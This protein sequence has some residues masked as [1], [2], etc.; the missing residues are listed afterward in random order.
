MRKL[1]AAY[2]KKHIVFMVFLCIMTVLYIV[3]MY[4][5]KPWYDELYTYYYFISRGPVYSAIHWPL[6]NNHVGFSILSSCLDWIKD[7]F[8]RLRAVS[9]MAAVANLILLY[10]FAGKFMDVFRAAGV[11]MLYAGAGL[12]YRLSFQGRGYTL[13]TTCFLVALIGICNICTKDKPGKRDHAMFIIGMIGGLYIVPT[14]LYWVVTTCL[15]G[16]FCLLYQKRYER[17]KAAI[18]DGLIAALVTFCLYS[19]LWLAVGANLLS[20][21]SD[22]AYYGLHQFKVLAKAPVRSFV[23]GMQYMLTSPAIQGMP[24]AECVKGMPLYLHTLFGTFYAGSGLIVFGICILAVVFCLIRL[25]GKKGSDHDAF[26]E[27]FLLT[28]IIVIPVMFLI[29]SVHPF[30]RVV[31]FLMIPIAFMSVFLLGFCKD[32]RLSYIT[33]AVSL[34]LAAW[35]LLLPANH[36]PVADRE[37]DIAEILEQIDVSGMNRIFYTDD[38]QKYVLKFYYDAAPAE[39][40]TILDADCV[41]VSREM[42]DPSFAALVWPLLYAYSGEMQEY[43]GA[44]FEKKAETEAY[45]FYTRK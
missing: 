38:Y 43:I 22:G 12:V 37:N 20:K 33:V 6:T 17:I 36:A 7:P 41:L 27:I 16:G 1:D 10:V 29:Q 34:L 44:N 13:A 18:V 14:S 4:T 45:I 23:T 5:N 25:F 24:R 30:V 19:V 28:N 40:A 32:R 9:V 31:S 35:S 21:D 8:I 3:A 2:L 15:A 39:S 26:A 11:T 42:Q